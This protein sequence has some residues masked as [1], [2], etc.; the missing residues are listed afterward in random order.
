MEYDCRDL[1]RQ[2]EAIQSKNAEAAK[3]QENGG[4][5]KSD[6]LY[7]FLKT[8]KILPVTTLL[9]YFGKEKWDAPTD[10]WGMYN[11]PS[12]ANP[13]IPKYPISVLDLGH[14]ERAEIDQLSSELK[15][16]AAVARRVIGEAND[17]IEY[18]YGM[19]GLDNMSLEASRLI[20]NFT[21]IKTVLRRGKKGGIDMKKKLL[22]M[23]EWKKN[24]TAQGKK[25]VLDQISQMIQ[26]GC[27]LSDI[28]A[29]ANEER[30]AED[31]QE[32]ASG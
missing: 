8:D 6:N 9:V 12:N 15:L 26:N 2:I 30:Q 31:L 10:L 16:V 24:C 20:Q 21:G 25:E 13:S 23:E 1:L 17:S 4:V 11:L 7:H 22:S 19:P 18:T 29:Y 27:T 14:L 28:Q 32:A 3:N 5:N